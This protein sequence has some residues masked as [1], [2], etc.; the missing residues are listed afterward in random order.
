MKIKI[1]SIFLSSFFA[2]N[3]CFS[4]YDYFH[5]EKEAEFS[6]GRGYIPTFNIQPGRAS[7]SKGEFAYIE[8][9]YNAIKTASLLEG[10]K[11]EG[12][13]VKT[14]KDS[15][16]ET[17]SEHI[18]K[19]D[20]HSLISKGP[21]KEDPKPEE[22]A[23]ANFG[24]PS[25]RYES[26]ISSDG[27]DRRK[28][29]KKA[30]K[31]PQSIHGR[32]FLYFNSTDPSQKSIVAIGTGVVIS[33]QNVLTCGHNLYL[34][35]EKYNKFP[36]LDRKVA[37]IVFYPGLKGE[38][39]HLK[40][41]SSCYV[42]HPQWIASTSTNHD[43]GMIHFEKKIGLTTGYIPISPHS[44][45]LNEEINVTGYPGELEHYMYTMS[46]LIKQLELNKI[47]YDIDTTY[48]N[49][50][51]CIWVG[52]KNS[53]ICIGIHTTGVYGS[54][55]WNGGI[56][57]TH[58]NYNLIKGWLVDFGVLAEPSPEINSDDITSIVGT[59]RSYT[60]LEN[61][62]ESEG[63][64]RHESKSLFKRL[65]NDADENNPPSTLHRAGP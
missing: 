1:I 6:L 57:I 9:E 46:G 48:G 58:E 47:Y 38:K 51:S 55:K 8:V 36:Y 20:L 3:P 44:P 43:L 17:I 42:V 49:S 32:L 24:L 41:R 2:I 26:I 63:K 65:K 23:L 54:Y 50:G 30:K 21:K 34:D 11:G 37:Q 60:E 14:P 29:V 5:P 16:F 64:I 39:Y 28:K 15:N 19:Q 56:L 40:A 33:P 22:G 52:E 31:F 4:S 35:D 13:Y 27:R 62:T 10:N 25:V 12:F 7:F 61:K 53:P 18:I 59:K 45:K